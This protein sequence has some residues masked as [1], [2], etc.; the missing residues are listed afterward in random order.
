[1]NYW[2]PSEHELGICSW[3]ESA[4]SYPTLERTLRDRFVP[5]GVVGLLSLPETKNFTKEVFTGNK[6]LK[7]CKGRKAKLVL[8][9]ESQNNLMLYLGQFFKKI[10]DFKI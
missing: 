3:R 1:M 9:Y 2:G 4:L 8:N 7:D 6:Q 5:V 10:A